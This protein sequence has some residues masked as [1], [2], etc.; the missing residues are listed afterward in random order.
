MSTCDNIPLPQ[1]GTNIDAGANLGTGVQ[2]IA[3]CNFSG[4]TALLRQFVELPASL[5]TE[6][7]THRSATTNA[8]VGP[9]SHNYLSG[10]ALTSERELAIHGLDASATREAIGELV[11]KLGLG[12]VL[13]RNPFTLSGG[14]QAMLTIL[15]ALALAPRRLSL[16]SALEQL[17]QTAR[18]TI[19]SALKTC[20]GRGIHTLIADNRMQEFGHLLETSNVNPLSDNACNQGAT[21]SPSV[22][23]LVGLPYHIAPCALGLDR[24]TFRYES[25]LPVLKGL[26]YSFEPGRVYHLTGRNGA[27]KSTLA[28]ILCGILRPRGGTILKNGVETISPWKEPAKYVA[29][30]FQN[31]DLQLFSLTVREELSRSLSDSL[32]EPAWLDAVINAFGLDSVLDRH[33]LDLPYV[34]R[35]RVAMAA[36]VA[37]RRPWLIL[38]EPTLGQDDRN[39]MT[40]ARQ[41]TQLTAQGVGIIVVS[42][43]EWFRKVLPGQKLELINGVLL[44]AD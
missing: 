33:P 16:D 8:Y 44:S 3:G 21:A 11:E 5:S 37:M 9:D 42:H 40:L 19:I 39:A 7:D 31:P 14:E 35:K 1:S 43:S 18:A 38:D 24:I 6:W 23:Q 15:S 22:L 4:R 30:H 32:R 34:I 17:G 29:Y 12:H 41:L 25:G 13:Y 10:L 28:K 2:G 26:T 20:A 36:S 27:G